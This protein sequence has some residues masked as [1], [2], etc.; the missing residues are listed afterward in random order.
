ML[1]T[2][3]TRSR[4]NV[5]GHQVSALEF[6]FEFESNIPTNGPCTGADVR[7]HTKSEYNEL[8]PDEKEEFLDAIRTAAAR[9]VNKGFGKKPASNGNGKKSK[10]KYRKEKKLAREIKALKA[11]MVKEGT[12]SAMRTTRSTST[13]TDTN[14]LEFSTQQATINGRAATF[15]FD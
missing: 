2:L 1:K 4:D 6:D 12:I 8:S 13:T 5:P 7:Y 9:K 15:L 14:Q 11:T 10:K 3:P